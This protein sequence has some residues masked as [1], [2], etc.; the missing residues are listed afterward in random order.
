M[1]SATA[2]F[3]REIVNPLIHK[4]YPLTSPAGSPILPTALT[5][6]W[7]CAGLFWLRSER[8]QRIWLALRTAGRTFRRMLH[9]SALVAALVAGGILATLT[10]SP[11]G[12]AARSPGPA[13]STDHNPISSSIADLAAPGDADATPAASEVERVVQAKDGDTFIKLMLDAGVPSEDAHAAITA[14][15]K[16]YD[17]RGLRPG[18]RITVSFRPHGGPADDPLFLGFRFDPTVERA[19][20]VDRGEEGFNAEAVDRDLD[21]RAARVSGSID[22]NLY[23]AVTAAG[24]T[25]QIM[26]QLIRLFSWDVDFQRDIR[27]GDRFDMMVESM[28]APDG[29]VAGFGDILYAELTLSGVKHRLY[30]FE[31]DSYGVAYYD[32]KGQS[33]RK[34]L[35]KTPIDGAR[36]SSGYGVRMHPILG[37]TRMHRGIDFAAPT[38][39][40]IYAAGRGTIEKLGRIRGYGNYIRINHTDRYATAYAHMSRFARGLRIGSHVKQGDV[41]GYVGATGEATGPHLHYEVLVDS[42]QVNPM[43]VKLPSG[44]KLAGKELAAFR[45][46]QGEI[47][48]QLATLEPVTRVS[49]R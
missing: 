34:A 23:S 48:T 31:S 44:Y 8:R 45:A 3:E 17:P 15:N 10:A 7:G 42:A 27:P 9:G 5:I 14:M 11:D 6:R 32:D 29:R 40:P 26:A 47:K 49:M 33:A 35:L 21:T 12:K 38:G 19:I 20:R 4:P 18:Q 46:A 25:P 22:A 30:R 41:I 39:T 16:V 1:R 2:P 28:H 24:L 43:K 37:Y 13:A 36:L